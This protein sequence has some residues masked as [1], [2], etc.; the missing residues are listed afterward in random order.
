MPVKPWQNIRNVGR[1]ERGCPSI[2]NMADILNGD[3]NRDIEDCLGLTIYTKSVRRMNYSSC[4]S[5]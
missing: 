3:L 5:P 2:Q 4:F 1:A